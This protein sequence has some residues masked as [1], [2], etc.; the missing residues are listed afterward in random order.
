MTTRST[1]VEKGA[2]TSDRGGS[3]HDGAYRFPLQ[4]QRLARRT[5]PGV[6]RR[7]SHPHSGA[8]EI[9]LGMRIGGL[10]LAQRNTAP[11]KASAERTVASPARPSPPSRRR[12]RRSPLLQRSRSRP[13]VRPLR[14]SAVAPS[15]RSSSGV[16]A[17]H[18]SGGTDRM[19]ISVVGMSGTRVKHPAALADRRHTAVPRTRWSHRPGRRIALV[20]QGSRPAP[21]AA[22]A[23]SVAEALA[24]REPAEAQVQSC[25][26]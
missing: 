24:R 11:A 21:V 13:C 12:R 25:G 23:S 18:L 3:N 7:P 15:G 16:T 8:D 2:L 5:R 9:G 14:V 22:N 17:L 10:P 20:A 19:S 26:R 6:P 1:T 4:L